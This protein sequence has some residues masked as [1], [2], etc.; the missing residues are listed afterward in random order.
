MVINKKHMGEV[1]AKLL[2]S[3]IKAICNIAKGS[4]VQMLIKAYYS[5][6][7]GE[8]RTDLLYQKA[9]GAIMFNVSNKSGGKLF[10]STKDATVVA[11]IDSMF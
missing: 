11:D 9:I 6:K 1:K 5:N 7:H 4:I 2:D 3:T 8:V 10:L